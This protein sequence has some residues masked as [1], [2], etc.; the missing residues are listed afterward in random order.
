MTATGD[1]PRLPDTPS[2]VAGGREAGQEPGHEPPH[3]PPHEPGHERDREPGHE[4]GHERVPDPSLDLAQPSSSPRVRTQSVLQGASDNFGLEPVIR[5]QVQLVDPLLGLDLGG[6]K[7]LRLIGEGG[8]GRVYEARQDKPDRT[9]ALKVIRQG[10]TSEKTLRRFEREAEFLA[11]LQHAGIAQIYVVGTYS[12]DSGDVPF[13]VMEFIADAKPITH[14]VHENK[15]SL[16]DRLRLFKQVCNAVSHGHDRGIVHRDLKPG[17]ILIDSSSS[18]KVIDFGVARSTDS[19]LQITQLKT[20]TGQLVGTVQYMSPEQ[21]GENPN[22]LDERVDV[23]SLGVVLYEM[24][25]GCP[26]YDVRKKGIHEAARIICEQ[27]P[28]PLCSPRSQPEDAA[29]AKNPSLEVPPAVSAITQKCLEKNRRLRYATAGDLGSDIQR[30]LDGEPVVALTQAAGGRGRR[31]WWGWLGWNGETHGGVFQAPVTWWLVGA[32]VVAVLVGAAIGASLQREP[33]ASP[34]LPAKAQREVDAIRAVVLENFKA[35]ADEDLKALMGTLSKKL[36]RLDEFAHEAE[37]LFEATDVYI[38]LADF[39][40]LQLQP[41]FAAARIVQVTLPA[42]EK[43]RTEATPKEIFF[44]GNSALLPKWECCEYT[45]TFRKENGKWK[46][47]L[48]T[49]EPRPVGAKME[50]KE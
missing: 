46:L 36:P 8:M 35:C 31:R 48:I 42:D 18:P 21:F 13:Y 17:N 38:G 22:D 50:G 24:L 6:F 45:Q 28:E 15:L 19:D 30:F 32:A 39:E 29:T 23:Y 16:A 10:I 34:Q 4:P 49:D 40:I 47:D 12:S 43:D 26:P 7:I 5:A 25:A 37:A 2:P 1:D 41:P 33:E 44:R 14:Y 3:E 27:R 9:V 20:D 11:R